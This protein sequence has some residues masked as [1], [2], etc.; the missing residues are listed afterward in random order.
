MSCASAAMKR[1]R[2]SAPFVC[3]TCRRAGAR[4]T[5]RPFTTTRSSPTQD[6][7]PISSS[8]RDANSSSSPVIT[9][10]SAAPSDSA[11]VAETVR[12]ALMAGPKAGSS[13]QS[14]Q[15]SLSAIERLQSTQQSE[16]TSSRRNG[17]SGVSRSRSAVGQP[18]STS[19]R[20]KQPSLLDIL[21]SDIEA[22][23]EWAKLNANT[24][25]EPLGPHRLHVYA[26]RR[27]THLTLV[28]APRLAIDT[29]S[30]YISRTTTS[31]SERK[32]TISV[33]LSKSTGDIGFRKA[34]RGTYDA[35]FQL[36]A[37]FLEQMK[38]RGMFKDLSRLEVIMRGFGP[39]REAIQKILLGSEGRSLRDR[40]VSVSDATRLKIGG[41]RSPK[42][43]RLG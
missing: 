3:P 7:T 40:I 28:Q 41:C 18:R 21:G 29:V 35:A 32:K 4:A 10:P 1:I 8:T 23:E 2:R 27:N 14:E 24:R 22:D 6:D 19:Q 15:K 13:S 33:L 26:H 12:D 17:Q 36:G 38:E 11:G 9:Q 5:T 16:P 39:G 31:A 30:S 34:G 37:Y 20:R 43:R 25:K 42:P